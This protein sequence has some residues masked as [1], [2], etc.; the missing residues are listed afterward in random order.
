V[1]EGFRGNS[2]PKDF[3]TL[4]QLVWL[5]FNG[6][7]KDTTAFKAF[8]SQWE[9]QLK[10]MKNSPIAAFYDTLYKTAYPGY[11][12]MIIIP[13]MSQLSEVKLD[14]VYKIYKDRFADASD[15]KF[16]LVGNFDFD[17]ITP[18]IEKYFG[19][20]PDLNREETWKNIYPKF[21]DGKTNLTIYKGADPQSMVGI[22]MSE[23]FRWDEKTILHLRMLNEILSIKLVEVI[24]EKLSGVYSP[25]IM[26]NWDHYPKSNCQMIVM[27]GCSPKT[28]DKLTKAV[29]AEIKKIIRN[30]PTEIDLKKAQEALLRSRETDLEKN[31][32]WLGKLESIYFNN[33][34]PGSV[35]AYKERVNAVTVSDLQT[36]AETC[37]RMDHYVR[38][39][40]MPESEK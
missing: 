28:T 40:L 35:T 2:T 9:N 20:L 21:A 17:T 19:S 27:F 18:M 22:V 23:D 29:F 15:F 11:K 13:T 3:E 12:R 33:D 37:F 34:S 32:F 24:R 4:M 38:V 8:M 5:Y 14:Q 31:D 39:V 7:R 1:K 26:I 25:R 10:F 16:F 30:G 36:T 6:P